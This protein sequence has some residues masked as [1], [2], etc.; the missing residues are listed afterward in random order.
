MKKKRLD[1]R[2]LYRDDVFALLCVFSFSVSMIVGTESVA[3]LVL[4]LALDA[5]AAGRG[6]LSVM[7]KIRPVPEKVRRVL[8]GLMFIVFAGTWVFLGFRSSLEDNAVSGWVWTAA[9]FFTVLAVIYFVGNVYD[10][11]KQK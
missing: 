7:G 6:V 2:A 1:F 4:T 9:L 11:K 8:E 10:R 5:L 3:G